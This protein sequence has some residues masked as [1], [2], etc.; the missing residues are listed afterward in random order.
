M[1]GIMIPSGFA[2]ESTLHYASNSII[3]KNMPSWIKN[4]AELWSQDKITDDEFLNSINYLA[5]SNII[6]GIQ[7][8]KYDS[9]ENEINSEK[10]TH[11]KIQSQML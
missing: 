8:V 7:Y 11:Y 6:K 2:E 9:L 10:K 1:I 5:E 4:I 3:Q